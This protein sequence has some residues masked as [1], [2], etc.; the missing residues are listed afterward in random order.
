[1]ALTRAATLVLTIVCFGLWG[2]P[3]VARSDPD[4][5]TPHLWDT[6]LSVS[7]CCEDEHLQVPLE[8]TLSFTLNA[9][10][11]PGDT[12]T[13]EMPRFY[14]GTGIAPGGNIAAMDVRPSLK[15]AGSW[16]EGSYNKD[17]PF[18][19]SVLVLTVNSG[20]SFTSMEAITVILSI[21]NDLKLY[22]SIGPNSL[23]FSIAASAAGSATVIS[24]MNFEG[25]VQ[26]GSG[27]PT[28]CLS[29]NR[30]QCDY[31]TRTCTCQEGYGDPTLDVYH[32]GSA[33]WDCADTIC[34]SGPA[35]G[36]VTSYESDGSQSG[37]RLTECSGRGKCNRSSGECQCSSGYT[38]DACQRT[39]CP[40]DCSG[41]GR[42]LSTLELAGEDSA[43]PL[44]SG[45]TYGALDSL[46]LNTW[47]DTSVFGCLCDSSWAVG[48]GNG[49]VQSPEFFG[50]DCSL[51]RC[52]SGDDPD[53]LEDE[54]DCE[55]VVAAGGRG[56]GLAGN[57]CHVDCSKRGICN[58]QSG[59][60]SCFKGYYG[61]ACSL[62]SALA[63]G[64]EPSAWA[65]SR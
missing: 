61:E 5:T 56:T 48:L 19:D 15:W 13:V 46:T 14:T 29:G 59:V 27:C 58:H 39:L 57:L 3:P 62:R 1:M 23:L 42:C 60:C 47:D 54:T 7:P 43:L 28:D 16:T 25:V 18:S 22:C 52:P 40:N 38:G 9:D 31:C 26:V 24:A 4:N 36:D 32:P 64:G 41:H 10:L 11:L 49:E 35:F 12:I 6:L 21:S 45:G 53:T 50:P 30:G 20:Y 55:G 63:R 33:R 17:N 8:V 2:L 65:P 44:S 51:Q 34:P 37:H